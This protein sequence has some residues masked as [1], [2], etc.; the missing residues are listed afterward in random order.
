M[1]RCAR[2]F[3]DG[4]FCVD[5]T[6]VYYHGRE[7][8]YTLKVVQEGKGKRKMRRAFVYGVSCL[9]R[10]S[11]RYF[12]GV[13]PYKKG[14]GVDQT[15]GF[16]L[17]ELEDVNFKLSMFDKGFVCCDMFQRLEDNGKNYVLPF[18]RNKQLDKAWKGQDT[19]INYYLRRHGAPGKHVSILLLKDDEKTCG[20]RA[21]VYPEKTCLEE[22]KK[23]A[24]L[25][26]LR[27]NEETGFRCSKKVGAWTKSPSPSYR[28]LLITIS[29][30]LGNMCSSSNKQ[31]TGYRRPFSNY[32][33]WT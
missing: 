24:D 18:K 16:L 12:L 33:S 8:E 15:I 32:D 2:L 25:Y 10:P 14:D 29:L 13:M 3:R 11:N 21:Y 23:Q 6:N 28:I 4:F 5:Y 19:M 20:Y 17:A 27:W 22:A 26:R 30:I 7:A 9:V 1:A 31:A